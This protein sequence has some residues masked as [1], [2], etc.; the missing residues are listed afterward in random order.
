MFRKFLLYISL[1]MSLILVSNAVLAQ[2]ETIQWRSFEE[3]EKLMKEHP[4][5]IF[6]NAYTDWCGWCKRLDKQTFTNPQLVAYINE[7][8]YA[9]RMNAESKDPITYKGRTFNYKPD[10]RMHEL[11][12]ELMMGARSFPFTAI[13]EKD[14]MN[15]SPIPGFMKAGEFESILKYIQ[16]GRSANISW[17]DWQKTFKSTW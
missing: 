7:H 16:D 11:A 15:I 9:I 14:G 5:R 10:I 1:L 2:K 3:V 13:V 12:A 4:K 6:F 8:F 17:A